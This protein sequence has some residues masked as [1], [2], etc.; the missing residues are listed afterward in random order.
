M[1]ATDRSPTQKLVADILRCIKDEERIKKEVIHSLRQLANDLD[2][3]QR[4]MNIAKT[5]FASGGIAA[6]GL[7]IAGIAAAPFTFGTSLGLTAGGV[8]LGVSSGLGG[9]ATSIADKIVNSSTLKIAQAK[10]DDYQK[11]VADLASLLERIT[12]D[13]SHELRDR[14]TEQINNMEEGE[15]AVTL[16]L[17]LGGLKTAAETGGSVARSTA[18]VG[19]VAARATLAVGKTMLEAME[20]GAKALKIG[21]VV[22]SVLAVP[23]DLHTM[24]SNSIKIHKKTPSKTAE[25]IRETATH[26]EKVNANIR[27]QRLIQMVDKVP[28]DVR[29]LAAKYDTSSFLPILLKMLCLLVQVSAIVSVLL[30][31]LRPFFVDAWFP[32]STLVMLCMTAVLCGVVNLVL[33]MYLIVSNTSIWNGIESKLD[34]FVTAIKYV[35]RL[36]GDE[37]FRVDVRSIHCTIQSKVHAG[38]YM[39]HGHSEFILHAI[40]LV[41]D[42]GLFLYCGQE[43]STD[44]GDGNLLAFHED[45]HSLVV[46][47]HK[48]HAA[49]IEGLMMGVLSLTISLY[50][51]QSLSLIVCGFKRSKVAEAMNDLGEDF[52]RRYRDLLARSNYYLPAV[53]T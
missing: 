42:V 45:I 7:T 1:S 16:D 20:T 3:R 26:L 14:I 24:I 8:A 37:G 10:I 9:L 48:H 18:V 52:R 40:K 49:G 28:N 46:S 36:D 51:L 5:A 19:A 50:L 21:G 30:D 22:L 2:V 31:R 13:N 15:C 47:T 44:P 6:T 39:K 23:L 17:I 53:E 29:D 27:R 35:T 34:K 11:T 4:D 25:R 41:L 33:E 38:E 32:D 43:V 12:S